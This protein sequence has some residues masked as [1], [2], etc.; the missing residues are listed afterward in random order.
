M[1]EA[2]AVK[3]RGGRTTG[4]ED[5]PVSKRTRAEDS[6]LADLID[7]LQVAAADAEQQAEALEAF[8]RIAFEIRAGQVV[9]LLDEQ[10]RRQQV[11]PEPVAERIR[12]IDELFDA[13]VE[14]GD[15]QLFSEEA[16]QGSPLWSE[17][18][19]AARQALELLGVPRRPILNPTR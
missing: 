5:E 6:R 14:R 19:A 16:L 13:M 9:A 4:G 3:G 12:R 15:E 18:R 7:A 8:R 10:L 17:L 11:L 2:R 1:E